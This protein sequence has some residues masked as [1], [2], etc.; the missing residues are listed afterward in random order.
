[1]HAIPTALS[2]GIRRSTWKSF[3][4]A[5]AGELVEND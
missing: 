1:M 5:R 3:G 2:G 4:T